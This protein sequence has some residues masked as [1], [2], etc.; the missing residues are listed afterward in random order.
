[1]KKVGGLKIFHISLY[2]HLTHKKHI[3]RDPMDCYKVIETTALQNHRCAD[4]AAL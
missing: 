1:M 3:K 4:I 2:E